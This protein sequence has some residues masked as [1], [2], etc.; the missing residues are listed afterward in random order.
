MQAGR[1]LVSAFGFGGLMLAVACGSSPSSN[2]TGGGA[3]IGGC[4][5]GKSAANTAVENTDAAP[6]T[7]RDLTLRI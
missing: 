5:M 1:E 3:Y 7:M 6:A 2:S 4:A